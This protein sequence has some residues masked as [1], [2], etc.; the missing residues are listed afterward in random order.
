MPTTTKRVHIPASAALEAPSG[1]MTQIVGQD[2]TTP[3]RNPISE[4]L[5][6]DGDGDSDR[7][8]ARDGDSDGDG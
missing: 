1:E 8:A 5:D 3:V 2:E 7:D 6:G 4:K